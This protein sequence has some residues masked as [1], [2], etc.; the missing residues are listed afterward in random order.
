MYHGGAADEGAEEADHEVDSVVGRENTEVTEAG[1][2]RIDGSERDALLKIIFVGH[3]AAF[4]AA[5]G[6]RGIH[7]GGD[8]ATLTRDEVWFAFA[9]E[10]FPAM[11]TEEI[12]IWR[13]FGDEDSFEICC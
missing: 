6:A 13:R 11:R 9:A 8:V 1:G 12:G 5:A 4:G 10:F 2:E 3:H 7:D